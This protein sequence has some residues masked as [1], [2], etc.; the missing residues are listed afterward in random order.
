LWVSG[1]TGEG[2]FWV[3]GQW[4]F[5][6]VLNT[7]ILFKLYNSHQ[8]ATMH[9]LPWHKEEALMNRPGGADQGSNNSSCS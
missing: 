8:M 5:K 9:L 2:W 3:H 4:I 7:C 6:S 1:I